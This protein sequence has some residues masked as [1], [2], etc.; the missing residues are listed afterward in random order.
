MSDPVEILHAESIHK[1]FLSGETWIEVLQG[2]SLSVNRGEAVSIRGRSGCGKT[3][4]LNCISGLETPDRGTVKLNGEA[5]TANKRSGAHVPGRIGF[6]FQQ[7]YLLPELN[8][9]ENVLLAGRIA[10]TPTA[11]AKQRAHQLLDSVGLRERK[12]STVNKLSGGERQRVAI[13]RALINEPTIIL[14]DEPTG[15]L[16]DETADDVMDLLFSITREESASLILVT[17]SA[18]FA[19]RADRQ[20]ALEDGVIKAAGG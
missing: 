3:T 14:A 5:V 1:R 18:T 4:F 17:H 9:L 19:G 11:Q 12:Q 2:A 13:A 15:N 8:A 6:I 20:Y 7:F 10:G 16:D